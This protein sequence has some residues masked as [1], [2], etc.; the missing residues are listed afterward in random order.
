L[1]GEAEMFEHDFSLFE[2]ARRWW[3]WFSTKQRL[4]LGEDP[5]VTDATASDR[6]SID[7]GFLHHAQT[8][9]GGEQIPAA[10]DDSLWAH[11]LFDFFKKLPSA[12]S[13]VALLNGSPVN[14]DCGDGV[15]KGTVEDFVE[16]IAALARVIEA[17][18]H[19]DRYGDVRWHDIAGSPNDL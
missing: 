19:F 9:F 1:F 11:M 10:E 14:G 15:V 2:N 16:V 17:T 13:L 4:G 6:D 8:I 18:S 5:R 7:P 12:W 3:Q